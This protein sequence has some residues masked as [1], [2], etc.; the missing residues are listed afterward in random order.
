MPNES[1]DPTTFLKGQLL[2]GERALFN[3]N[4]LSLERCVF[5]NGE[6][7]LKESRD[8]TLANC[9]FEW[10]YPLWYCENVTAKNCLWLE[11]ARSGVWYSNKVRIAQSL[12]QAPKNFRRCNDVELCDVTFSDAAETLWMCS[13]VTLSN[14]QATGDYF[15]MNSTDINADHLSLTGN[16]CFDGASNVT[17]RNS[18]LISKDAFWNTRNVTVYDSVIVGEYLGWN[19]QN[20]TFV[21]CTIESLQGL[22]YI[23]NL[24]MVN[25]KTVNTTLAF[26]KSAVEV[27]L[28]SGVDSVFNPESGTI[29]CDSVQE[30]IFEPDQIDPAKTVITCKS[31]LPETKERAPWR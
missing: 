20:L 15:A 26:E 12:I 24:K 8:I 6:S 13:N 11:M 30:L 7:P 14:V 4:N 5:A 22:C 27:S 16:Y 29:E 17:V 3:S 18:K 1:Q 2:E 28:D 9:H 25:C 21:N 10:K 19:S 31:A 23:D